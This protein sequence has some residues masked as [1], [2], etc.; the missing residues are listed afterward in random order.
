MKHVDD[1]ALNIHGKYEQARGQA[2][3][4]MA[5]WKSWWYST[6]HYALTSYVPYP[7]LP[8]DDANHCVV[9]IS[10]ARMNLRRTNEY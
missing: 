3:D 5:G 7:M 6:K 10:P 1:S 4:T 2:V 8:P 9:P